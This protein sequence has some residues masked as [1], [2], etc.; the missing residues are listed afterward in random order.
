MGKIIG[1]GHENICEIYDLVPNHLPIELAILT[2]RVNASLCRH[3]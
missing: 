3:C 2:S 1:L